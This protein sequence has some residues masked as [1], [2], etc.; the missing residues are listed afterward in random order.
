MPRGVDLVDEVVCSSAFARSGLGLPQMGMIWMSLG[1]ICMEEVDFLADVFTGALGSLAG[2]TG[3][4]G[5]CMAAGG[6][7]R[8]ACVRV[9]V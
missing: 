2:W 4:D 8:C 1:E 6:A 9:W 5:G 3:G 7:W